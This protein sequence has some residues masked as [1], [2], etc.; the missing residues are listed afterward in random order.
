MFL[1][2]NGGVFC[3]SCHE[4]ILPDQR[5]V[6]CR[7]GVSHSYDQVKY[8]CTYTTVEP[9]YIGQYLLLQ[10]QWSLSIEDTTG[11]QLAVLY[12][13]VSLIQRW[14]CAQL[15]VVGTADSV[16]IRVVSLI[17]THSW[18]PMESTVDTSPWLMCM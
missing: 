3:P 13:E 17:Q 7:C 11:T 2:Q 1:L 6:E 9:L 10:L 5:R 12:R 18:V 15:Y 14:I 8:I 16:L 4:G